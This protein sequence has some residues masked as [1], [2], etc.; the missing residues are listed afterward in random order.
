L[1]KY[2]ETTIERNYELRPELLRTS[3][4]EPTQKVDRVKNRR[5]IT[6]EVNVGSQ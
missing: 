5:K 4:K 2:W 3:Q 6:V 1:E